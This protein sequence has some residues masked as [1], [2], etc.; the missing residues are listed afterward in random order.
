[1]AIGLKATMLKA[2]QAAGW[3]IGR[4]TKVLCAEIIV[5]GPTG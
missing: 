2:A 5:A 4:R 1:M 3:G